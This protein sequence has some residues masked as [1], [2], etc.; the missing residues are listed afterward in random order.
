MAEKQE[1]IV[2]NVHHEDVPLGKGEAV[3]TKLMQGD[4]NF[5]QALFKEP[6]IP[7]NAIAIQLYL[8]S[9]IGFFCSTS[10]GFDSSLFGTLLANETFQDFMNVGNVGIGAGIVTSMNQI[11][12]VAALPFIGPF[13]DT[14]GRRAGMFIGGLIIVV[15]VIIQGTCVANHNVHQFMGGR[16]FMGMGVSIISAAGPCYVVEVSHPA[17]RGVVTALYNVCWSVASVCVS[18]YPSFL[19]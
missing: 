1:V 14:W 11:G 18:C 3:T 8:I 13:I 5:A 6:P 10:N 4:D 16:F 2:D 15:G 12:G 17:Y 19:S 9:L 7:F